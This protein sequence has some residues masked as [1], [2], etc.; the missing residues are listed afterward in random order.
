MKGDRLAVTVD[1]KDNPCGALDT[2][3]RQDDLDPMELVFLYY[4]G[5]FCHLVCLPEGTTEG[6]DSSSEMYFDYA[7][8][9]QTALHIGKV[10]TIRRPATRD[11][12]GNGAPIRVYKKGRSRVLH[13]KD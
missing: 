13:K 2:E 9:R 10:S 8:G 11:F 4:E 3:P 5:R 1:Q 12:L 7:D 6:L